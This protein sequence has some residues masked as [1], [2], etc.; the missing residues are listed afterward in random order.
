M[1]D[2]ANAEAF[3]GGPMPDGSLDQLVMRTD[4]EMREWVK[5]LLRGK[6]TELR[7]QTEAD[8]AAQAAAQAKRDRR[9]AKRVTLTRR[10]R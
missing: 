1:S 7:E 9:N 3:Y 4:A 8:I 2:R 10:R 5:G 6:L